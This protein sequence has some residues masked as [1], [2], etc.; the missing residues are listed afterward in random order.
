MTRSTAELNVSTS[1]SALR[2]MWREKASASLDQMFEAV[3]T[4]EHATA[5]YMENV[6]ILDEVKRKEAQQ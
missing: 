5:C 3:H 2:K 4:I 6:R 1:A